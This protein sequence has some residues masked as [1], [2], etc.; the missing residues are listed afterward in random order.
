MKIS[1]IQIVMTKLLCASKRYEDIEDILQCEKVSCK[2]GIQSVIEM[3][4]VIKTSRKSN[5]MSVS[6]SMMIYM[7]GCLELGE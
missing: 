3:G 4:T 6:N 2:Q 5:L 7:L 1:S